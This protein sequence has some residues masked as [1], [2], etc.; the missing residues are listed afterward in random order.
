[1]PILVQTLRQKSKFKIFIDFIM[2]SLINFIM[3][4]I[5]NVLYCFRENLIIKDSA[6]SP[7]RPNDWTTKPLIETTSNKQNSQTKQLLNDVN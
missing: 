1:M 3:L 5:S 6:T 2:I 7:S 4:S